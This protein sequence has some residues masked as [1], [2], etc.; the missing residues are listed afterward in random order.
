M[1]KC[2]FCKDKY[3]LND[4]EVKPF[5]VGI[6]TDI[7]NTGKEEL[8]DANTFDACPYCINTIKGILMKTLDDLNRR[9]YGG[10]VDPN[11]R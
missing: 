8:L 2:Y 9:T 1:N 5:Y 3:K 10:M 7:D 11:F 6:I 4:E